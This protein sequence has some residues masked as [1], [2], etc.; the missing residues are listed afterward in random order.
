VNALV[1]C[2]HA[3]WAWLKTSPQLT[4]PGFWDDGLEEGGTAQ[5]I[6][7]ALL[8]PAPASSPSPQGRG[9][10]GDATEPRFGTHEG[11][12]RRALTASPVWPAEAA[13]A[14]VGASV[15]SS[16]FDGPGRMTLGSCAAGARQETF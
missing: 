6:A 14:L 2:H 9:L 1:A 8:E 4:L 7:V 5:G 13:P 16:T 12:T 11:P 3:Y 10:T 15:A